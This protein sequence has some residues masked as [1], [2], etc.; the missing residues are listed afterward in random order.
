MYSTRKCGWLA[1]RCTKRHVQVY[2]Q[3]F[4]PPSARGR[5]WPGFSEGQPRGKPGAEHRMLTRKITEAP[6]LDALAALCAAHG[7]RFN[8]INTSAAMHSLGLLA[9]KA[10]GHPEREAAQVLMQ[11]LFARFVGQLREADPR[12]LSS[13]LWA[14]QELD[15]FPGA[16]ELR[17]LEAEFAARLARGGVPRRPVIIFFNSLAH[18]VR[19][20][21]WRPSVELLERAEEWVVAVVAAVGGAHGMA[22][23]SMIH[24]QDDSWEGLRARDASVMLWAW[25]HF[26]RPL[27]LDPLEALLRCV[28]AGTGSAASNSGLDSVSTGRLIFARLDRAREPAEVGLIWR[29]AAG[30]C[31]AAQTSAALA[32]LARMCSESRASAAEVQAS[33]LL[34]ELVKRLHVQAS[35][36]DA[37][38]L[39]VAVWALS[40]LGYHPGE[41]VMRT[42]EAA[43]A[44]QVALGRD[45]TPRDVAMLLDG[46]Q[47]LG[48]QLGTDL[49]QNRLPDAPGG[50]FSGMDFEA[51]AARVAAAA[52]LAA[53]VGS[54]ADDAARLRSAAAEARGRAALAEAQ[55][56]QARARAAALEAQLS[57]AQ[58]RAAELEQQL[59]G[60]GGG[61]SSAVNGAQP[62]GAGDP[63]RW[64]V[65]DGRRR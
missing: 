48:W 29:V 61:A 41:Q 50:A 22:A 13:A 37:R 52:A 25:H 36:A 57:H 38:Q 16:P 35:E 15:A 3:R 27:P 53:L 23:G 49:R 6:N 21:D 26:G 45:T 19:A 64:Q 56:A 34:Q 20:A 7:D 62:S 40:R 4:G 31:G 33:V 46:F 28:V 14:A 51:Q 39:A 30:I 55:L 32:S 44:A 58:A 47:R 59:A 5:P 1:R 11:S 60:F 24:R 54:A 8:Y 10:D 65:V 43:F 17:A 63:A 18:F 42:L 9:P 12:A 2:A